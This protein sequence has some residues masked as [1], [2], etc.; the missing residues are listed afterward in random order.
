MSQSVKH[1]PSSQVL[2]R[3]DLTFRG[4]EP[5]AGLCADSSGPGACFG[6]CVSSLSPPLP[7]LCML[8]FSLSL[9]Q[10]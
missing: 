2:R 5:H 10:K 6:F 3:S 9:S 4:F 8:S 1:P 7:N